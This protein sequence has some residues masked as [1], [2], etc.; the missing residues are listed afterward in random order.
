[1]WTVH[2]AFHRHIPAYLVA[3]FA[4]KLS[5]LALTAPPG[6]LTVIIPFIYNLVNRHPNCKALLHRPDGPTGKGVIY[7][8][9]ACFGHYDSFKSS[10]GIS[11]YVLHEYL[12][13]FPWLND[14]AYHI[15]F[16]YNEWE[17]VRTMFLQFFKD[18]WKYPTWRR[19]RS[20]VI[21][22]H[23][24]IC[25]MQPLF[26]NIYHY[27][28]YWYSHYRFGCWPIWHERIRSN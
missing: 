4:K 13:A 18:P 16:I 15:F 24:T 11:M 2:I 20:N 9:L 7:R 19:I 26:F 23:M 27:F 22:S 8:Q 10:Q 17:A 3:A 6:G 21:S 12:W 1:M 5:R 28:L 25:K 14:I